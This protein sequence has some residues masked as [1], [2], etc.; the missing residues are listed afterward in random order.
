MKPEL[1]MPA[2]DMEKLKTAFQYG[3]DAVYA[4]VP[5]FSLRAREQMFNIKSVKEAVDYTRSLGKKIYLTLN[6]FPHNYKIPALKNALKPLAEL[7]PDAFIMAD[8]G[9]IML[10]KEIAPE[11][12]IH[13]SVQANNVN[14]ASAKFW[15]KQGIERIILSREISLAEVKGIHEMN[16]N[17][18]LEFFVH[19]SICM[20][21]SG[22]C[23]L[24]NYFSYR[25]A[26]QGTCAHS[27]RWQYKVHEAHSKREIDQEEA[28]KR[29]YKE[30]DHDYYLEEVSRPGEYME[31]AEDE[32]GTYI[33]NSRDMCLVEYLKE[34]KDAGVC[35]FKVEGRNKTVFYVAT[36]AKTYRQAIDDM[37]AGKPFNPE[38]ITELAK[39]SNRG[40]IPG[41]L[42][43]NPREKAQE[44]KK[45]ITHQTH[46]FVGIVRNIHERDN[47]KFYE[48]EVKGRIDVPDTVEV[49][50]PSKSFKYEMVKITN[51]KGEEVKTVHPGQ[52]DNVLIQLPEEVEIGAMIRKERANHI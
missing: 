41:F 51:L 33:M 25:D 50:S 47:Q 52:K 40:F 35:S 10:S 27:C 37:E 28:E 42:M 17:L 45:R 5:M 15:H 49:F 48:V 2:G 38:Y 23:L 32:H 26:N 6:I 34:L 18:E 31:I 7:K 20:A 39:T 4:G 29:G 22:R 8:P 24:S 46:E 11:I 44:Y 21:Y 1:L 14:W 12:P 3:A 13:L 16:P 9:V 43:A 30:L 36:V 19:G